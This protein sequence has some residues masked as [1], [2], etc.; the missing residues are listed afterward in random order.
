MKS[1]A[2]TQTLAAE[3]V[4]TFHAAPTLGAI[5]SREADRP[6]LHPGLTEGRPSGAE[7]HMVAAL[8]PS[9]PQG[10][11]SR[12]RGEAPGSAAC[13]AVVAISRHLPTRFGEDLN[14]LCVT[15]SST[16]FVNQLLLS[17][18]PCDAPDC[19][20][21]SVVQ[22]EPT[23]VPA[24]A[25]TQ[26]GRG[27]DARFRDCRFSPAGALRD[28][29]SPSIRG[30]KRA[31][32]RDDRKKWRL[33]RASGCCI[34]FKGQF[35]L[36]LRRSLLLG[37]SRR[38]W[39]PLIDTLFRGHDVCGGFH[40]TWANAVHDYCRAAFARKAARSARACA[41]SGCPARW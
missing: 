32:T 8:L 37:P 38:V 36:T 7:D 17:R 2:A 25:G 26:V 21:N 9:A 24:K 11:Y 39:L 4:A 10:R 29:A 33:L 15:R 34:V 40:G 1:S 35:P 6:G 41:V 12:A 22:C 20:E 27:L 13:A 18:Q 23:V 14:F 16:E 28:A 3:G 30:Q 19:S 31:A 5:D